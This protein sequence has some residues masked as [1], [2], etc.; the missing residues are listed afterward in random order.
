MKAKKVK[1]K[2]INESIFIREKLKTK[3]R[4][5]IES[6]RHKSKEEERAHSRS[7]GG[8]SCSG[9]EVQIWRWSCSGGEVQIW[10]WR[11]DGSP[12]LENEEA[13][14]TEA[15]KSRVWSLTME[16]DPDSPRGASRGA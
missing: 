12:D 7:G 14:A 11:S 9:G 2:L 13:A 15:S 5:Y 16:V 6:V 8:W 10:R 4:F 3:K 1:P